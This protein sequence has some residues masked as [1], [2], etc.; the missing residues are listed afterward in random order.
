MKSGEVGYFHKLNGAARKPPATKQE[1]EPE[2]VINCQAMLERWWEETTREQLQTAAA[3]LGVSVVALAML[4]WVWAK[5]HHAWAIPM[6]DEQNT[7]VGIR[8]RTSEG[9][10]FAVRGSHSGIFLPQTEA[11]RTALVAEGPTDAAAGL[12][13]GFFTIGRPS[14]SGGAG[15][16]IGTIQR[17]KINRVIIIADN[18]VRQELTKGR[19]PGVEG[20]VS[21]AEMLPVPCA[22]ILLPGPKD[23]REYIS[24]GGTRA[25]LDDQ[26]NHTVMRQP[27]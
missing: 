13:L 4:G 26:I 18:D 17:L 9:K 16:I 2:P 7:P 20:A 3:A 22:V 11:D 15:Q 24:L 27:T 10:K 12:T 23:L 21:L 6:R 8:L 19:N 5:E 14:C 25:M 1:P